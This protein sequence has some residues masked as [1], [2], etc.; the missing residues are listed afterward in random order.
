MQLLETQGVLA[1]LNLREVADTAGVNRGLIYQYFGSRRDL[2]QAALRRD[3][4]QRLG[5]IMALSHLPLR[6]RV[7]NLLRTLIA[8]HDAVELL[9]LLVLDG[10][11]MVRVLPLRESIIANIDRDRAAGA[12]A[13]DVDPEVVYAFV[14][15]FI[16]GY[17]IYRERMGGELGTPVEALDSQIEQLFLRALR[18]LGN[19]STTRELDAPSSSP[20]G[21]G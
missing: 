5:A 7:R 12:I 16:Y 1:G 4:R 3:V 19:L 6:E 21:E 11:E 15:S 8:H 20:D 14:A 9:T 10:D 17:A 18:G 13:H 2:I